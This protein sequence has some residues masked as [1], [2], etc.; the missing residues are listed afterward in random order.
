M[1][2]SSLVSDQTE[3]CNIL[4]DF[5]IHIA[6]E[7]GINNQSACAST[8][9]QPN[10]QT[11]KDNCLV[12]G[13]DNL[14]FKPVSESQVKKK[15]KFSQLA[16]PKRQQASIVFQLNSESGDRSYSWSC[17]QYF[18][19]GVFQNQFPDRLKVAKVSRI[20]KKDDP[21]IKRTTEL[22]VCS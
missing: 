18:N 14:D 13:F 4:N 9:T 1:E 22:L 21:Y 8:T 2:N 7:I 5:Y 20:F 19:K 16:V 11:I 17:V 15:Y 6:K 12:E 3:V 10:I